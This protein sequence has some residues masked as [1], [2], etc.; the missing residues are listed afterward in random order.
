MA[1]LALHPVHGAAGAVFVRVGGW[2]VPGHYGDPTLEYGAVREAVGV[3]DRSARGKLR[4]T[5]SD[6]VRFLHGMM[7]NTVEGLSKREGNYA[8]LTNPKGQTLTDVWVH[9]RGEDFLLETE[10]GF[11]EKLYTSLDRY[12][13]AD[14]V[15]MHDMTESLAVLGVLGPRAGEMLAGIVGDVP[16]DL[17]EFHTVVRSFHG[18]EVAV[19]ARSFAGEPGYD[20]WVA[21]EGSE[22]LWRALEGAGGRPVGFEAL[23]ILRVEAGMPRYGADV[24]ERVI[25]LEAGLYSAVDFEKGCFIGQE[26]IAKMHNLGKPRRYLVGLQVEADA[27]PAPGTPVCAEE[28]EIGRITSSL[29]SVALGRVIALASVRRGFQEPGQAVS[30]P[31]GVQ[32]EVTE[33]PFCRKA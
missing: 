25:P 12:L 16:A 32:A 22:A 11:Q 10:P 7:S 9:N 18:S 29:R 20:L 24:D 14:D 15:E 27:P 13:I 23:E 26:A 31:G 1:K 17:P 28:K 21:V 8:T 4:V 30:L 3:A 2:E 19:V 5:G 33:L 6:R